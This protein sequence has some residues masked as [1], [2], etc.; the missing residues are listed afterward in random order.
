MSRLTDEQLSELTALINARL[1]EFDVSLMPKLSR[2]VVRVAH[3]E[4]IRFH[5]ERGESWAMQ[6]ISEVRITAEMAMKLSKQGYALGYEAANREM[7]PAPKGFPDEAEDKRN[8]IPAWRQGDD[9][10]PQK[11]DEKLSDARAATGNPLGLVPAEPAA[12]EPVQRYGKGIVPTLD[13]VLAELRRESM[14]GV[15]PTMA[16]FD[17]ARP[18]TWATAAAHLVRL[19]LSWPQLAE[20]AELKPRKPGPGG[21]PKARE[22]VME[23]V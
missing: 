12:D 22:P 16:Q 9:Y 10:A 8:G 1:D 14:G 6:R 11:G 21:S 23:G 2:G 13:Q 4:I 19:K 15:M 18:A 5:E 17:E 20:L 7:S 3:D